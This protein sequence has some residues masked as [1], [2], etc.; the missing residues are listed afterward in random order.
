MSEAAH[1]PSAFTDIAHKK[2][3]HTPALKGLRH[4]AQGQPSLSE[5]TLGMRH[6]PGKQTQRPLHTPLL[7]AAFSRPSATDGSAWSQ[8]HAFS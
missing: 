1:A 4:S 6:T 2:P 8:T 7:P 3:L 5:A